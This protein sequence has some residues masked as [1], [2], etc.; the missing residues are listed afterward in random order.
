MA[1]SQAFIFHF[2]FYSILHFAVCQLLCWAFLFR[3]AA[4]SAAEPHVWG[5]WCEIGCCESVHHLGVPHK[6]PAVL[7]G[8][9]GKAIGAFPVVSKQPSCFFCYRNVGPFQR[10]PN[11]IIDKNYY[12]CYHLLLLLLLLCTQRVSW[13][14]PT[15]FS[16]QTWKQGLA[17][18]AGTNILLKSLHIKPISASST[19]FLLKEPVPYWRHTTQLLP[20]LRSRLL[21]LSSLQTHLRK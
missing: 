5:C 20:L 16:T 7:S 15:S 17:G 3:I 12:L 9:E 2:K 13:G 11:E 21:F 4:A 19:A 18:V 10:S 1:V 14:S 8:N 6:T